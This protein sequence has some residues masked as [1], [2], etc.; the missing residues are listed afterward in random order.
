M[1]NKKNKAH[2]SRGKYNATLIKAAQKRIQEGSQQKENVAPPESA[3]SLDGSRIIN[4]KQL[5]SF[6]SDVSSH[7]QSCRLGTISLIGE[8]YRNG[9]SSVL[10]AKCSS[11]RADIAFSTS[12][13]IGG[14]GNG[15]RWESNLAA[16]WGQ[17]ASG[18]GHARLKEVMSVLGVPV[19]TKRSFIVT[20]SAVNKCWWESLKEQ[21]A[22]EEKELAIER[23]AYHEGVPA[24][25]VVVDAGWSKRSHKHS[26]NAKS[27]VAIIVGME[28]KKLLY[29]GVRNKYC[30]CVCT[31]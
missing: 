26:Y 13:K 7:S 30:Q 8:T 27:G 3:P 16:V 4:L 22:V 2:A 18:G 24:I 1:G 20:E 6:I 12:H 21:T 9:M 19:M 10:S 11:C 14:V 15:K 23:G 28:T 25:T 5:E 29:V 31:S 17:M